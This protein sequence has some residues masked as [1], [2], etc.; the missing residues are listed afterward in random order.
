MIEKAQGEDGRSPVAHA[1]LP[2]PLEFEALYLAN[3]EAFHEY[4]RF[5]LRTD[6]AAEAA[7]HRG[8]L[9]I[10]RHWD[11]LLLESNLHH[12]VW[13]IMRRT[14]IDELLLDFRDVLAGMDSGSGLYR[15]LG[16]LPQRQ[17]DVV[18]LRYIA[19]VDTRRIAWIMGITPS[20]VD[21][22][23]RKARERLAPAHRR[24]LQK[25]KPEESK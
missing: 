17:F 5:V 2:L 9:E 7:V 23:C 8:F 18:V 1:P 13:A 3:Q 24:A 16:K 11:S 20:T 12:H 25:K 10:L 19:K 4:A 14:V 22:H 21:Y 15:A 6:D